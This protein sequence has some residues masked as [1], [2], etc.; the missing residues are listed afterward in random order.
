[1]SVY[2]IYVYVEISVCACVFYIDV[3]CAYVDIGDIWFIIIILKNYDNIWLSY[4]SE[5]YG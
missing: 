5:A 3:C 4:Y 2:Y 1:M